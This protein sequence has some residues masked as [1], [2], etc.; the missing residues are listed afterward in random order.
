VPQSKENFVN[1]DTEGY[2]FSEEDRAKLGTYDFYTSN[3]SVE[4]ALTEGT[5][6]NEVISYHI[7]KVAGY[8][9]ILKEAGI[10][11]LFRPLHEAAGN[12]AQGAWFWWGKEGAEPYKRLW[13]HLYSEL[14]STYGLDNLIWVFTVQ[15]GDG[16][17]L[18]S[19][20]KMKEWY[21]GDEYV[22][23]V[24]ADLYETAGFS[25]YDFF[26]QVNS[27]V[28][29][30]K[31]VALCECGNLPDIEECFSD[32]TPWL[33]F[34]GW[35]SKDGD[36]WALY[37]RNSDGTYSWKNSSSQWREAMENSHTINRGDFSY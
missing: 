37:N 23:I 13:K 19:V 14:T 1:V 4:K 16:S 36:S 24:G 34:L 30:R 2:T 15:T 7:W 17:D 11:V 5:W 3:F 20:D 10:P 33:Y 12:Y 8:L 26:N 21:P 32:D 31:M 28:G 25:S 22:D 27:S 35:C 29:G 18:A 9:G 6:Q